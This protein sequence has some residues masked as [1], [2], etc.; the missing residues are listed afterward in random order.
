MCLSKLARKNRINPDAAIN[1]R[2]YPRLKLVKRQ[3]M[4]DSQAVLITEPVTITIIIF[5]LFICMIYL[6]LWSILFFLSLNHCMFP[7]RLV[8]QLLSLC[9]LETQGE[10]LLLFFRMGILCTKHYICLPEGRTRPRPPLTGS[11]MQKKRFCKH[12]NSIILLS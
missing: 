2:N 12:R 3:L 1:S 5:V 10:R 7:V 4:K 6:L 11:R 8:S 9:L